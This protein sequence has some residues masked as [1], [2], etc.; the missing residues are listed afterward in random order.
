MNKWEKYILEQKREHLRGRF[1]GQK[2][3]G[4]KC[5]LELIWPSL[6]LDNIIFG[7]NYIST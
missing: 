7:L 1:G 4:E 6:N 3:G 5:A 2:S